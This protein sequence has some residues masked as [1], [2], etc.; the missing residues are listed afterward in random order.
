M[1]IYSMIKKRMQAYFD[2]LK[3]LGRLSFNLRGIMEME[4][5]L[6]NKMSID[7]ARPDA[8]IYEGWGESYQKQEQ[9]KQQNEA[10]EKELKLEEQRLQIQAQQQ[11]TNTMLAAGSLVLGGILVIVVCVYLIKR[12]INWKK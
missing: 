12:M 3:R 1:V 10:K 9:L 7:G 8:T 4:N 5:N 11:Q 6:G 2:I